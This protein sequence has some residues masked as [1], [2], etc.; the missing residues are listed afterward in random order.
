MQ[1]LFFILFIILTYGFTKLKQE[2]KIQG[3]YRIEYENKK[4]FDSKISFKDSIYIKSLEFEKVKGSIKKFKDRNGKCVFYLYDEVNENVDS[5]K[6]SNLKDNEIIS[7]LKILGQPIIEF[8]EPL[9]DTIEFK[10]VYSG[11]LN[12]II[13]RGIL[14]KE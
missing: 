13:E 14:V 9:K 10:I 3:I 7:K 4:T 11:Q 12:V 8:T 5:T 1:K 2:C 6:L